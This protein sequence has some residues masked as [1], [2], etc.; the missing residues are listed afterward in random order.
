[1]AESTPGY[2]QKKVIIRGQLP[3][4][5]RD[6]HLVDDVERHEEPLARLVEEQ[7]RLVGLLQRHQQ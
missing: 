2:G 3:L 6:K 7:V 4:P 1:M 5:N